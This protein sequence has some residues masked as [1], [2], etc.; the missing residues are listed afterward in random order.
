MS[1]YYKYGKGPIS[2]QVALIL[3]TFQAMV[4]GK[5]LG[6]EIKKDLLTLG[7]KIALGVAFIAGV[8]STL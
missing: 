7:I 1:K 8:L 4:G 5:K 3:L 6:E 2:D